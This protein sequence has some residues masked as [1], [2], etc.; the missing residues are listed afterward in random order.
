MGTIARFVAAMVAS[1]LPR[2]WWPRIEFHVPVRQA[3]V[4]SGIATVL[5]GMA[6]GIP[7]F[8]RHAQGN[9]D[10]A[11][12]TVLEE[13]GWRQ[14][15]NAAPP[16]PGRG[17]MEWAAS[18][19]SIAT[20]A[21]TPLGLLS[22]YLVFTGW[23]RAVSAYVDDAR[24]DPML[25]LVDGIAYRWR[26]TRTARRRSEARE[27]LEGPEVPDRVVPGTAAGLPDAELVVISSRQKP[28]WV[29]GA[30]IIT[31]EAW[32]RLGKPE[33]RKTPAGLRTLYP[34]T[35]VRDHEALRKGVPYTLPGKRA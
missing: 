31:D 15:T 7:G 19:L 20:F 12:E 5:A 18:W 6:I 2:R 35:E 1:V 9:A 21:T 26:T 11:I 27:A 30:F 8:L 16:S 23:L 32:Y 29:P 3:V 13:T 17:Q 4:A 22:I 33:E 25:S 28:G 10:R 34:L 14:P 24:G